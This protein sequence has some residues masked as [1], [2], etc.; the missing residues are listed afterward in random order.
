MGAWLL[1]FRG[2]WSLI[3][4]PLGNCHLC[5]WGSDSRGAACHL[6]SWASQKGQLNPGSRRQGPGSWSPKWWLEWSQT[7]S[8]GTLV[9]G[10]HQLAVCLLIDV[11]N[12]GRYFLARSRRK[13]TCVVSHTLASLQGTDGRQREARSQQVKGAPDGGLPHPPGIRADSEDRVSYHCPLPCSPWQF[14]LH[15]QSRPALLRFHNRAWL[16]LAC[17][18]WQSPKINAIDQ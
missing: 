4:P 8:L 3:F 11:W 2:K 13:Q 16:R 14:P 18:R 10:Q 7:V 12:P 17:P 9:P 1:R 6:G 15:S 5:W